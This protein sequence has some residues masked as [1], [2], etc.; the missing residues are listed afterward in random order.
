MWGR[1]DSKFWDS[2]K[3]LIVCWNDRVTHHSSFPQHSVFSI[4]SPVQVRILKEDLQTH[5]AIMKRKKVKINIYSSCKNLQN[6]L[7]EAHGCHRKQAKTF[8]KTGYGRNRGKNLRKY[9]DHSSKCLI[10]PG[11]THCLL[12]RHHWLLPQWLRRDKTPGTPKSLHQNTQPESGDRNW[13]GHSLFH[14]QRVPLKRPPDL[15]HRTE[16]G[17]RNK[18]VF[19]LGE[20]SCSE[21]HNSVKDCKE[22][23]SSKNT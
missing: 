10:H 3:I 21:Y 8:C 15:L 13:A 16:I 17:N 19:M 9:F 7:T 5:K 1:E 6:A 14:T 18:N 22:K 12:L 4:I 23:I 2:D 11:G 20:G